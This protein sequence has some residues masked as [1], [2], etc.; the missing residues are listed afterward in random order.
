MPTIE[1][2]FLL[3]E[4]PTIT[5]VFQGAF[6]RNWD[7]TTPVYLSATGSAAAGEKSVLFGVVDDIKAH[8]LWEADS[9]G[10]FSYGTMPLG[11]TKSGNLISFMTDPGITGYRVV[12]AEAPEW[13]KP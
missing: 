13:I 9:E 11:P 3:N 7:P 8:L 10:D 1:P 12:K 5:H 6:R 2:L 4:R